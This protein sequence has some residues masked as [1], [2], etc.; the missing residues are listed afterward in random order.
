MR[1]APPP[2]EIGAINSPISQRV[3]DIQPLV[4]VEGGAGGNL[5]SSRDHPA[6]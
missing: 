3:L 4:E 6:S 5:C 2:P 1:P